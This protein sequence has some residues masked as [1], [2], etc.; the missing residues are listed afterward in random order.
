MD[1]GN[2]IK[3]NNIT[4][5]KRGIDVS[6]TGNWVEN[7]NV[8]DNNIGIR[9]T[10]TGNFIIRNGVGTPLETN[11]PTHFDIDPSNQYAEIL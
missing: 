8:V 9:V 11:N 4:A 10:G 6:S 5:N 2:R 1:P 7:N 3:D